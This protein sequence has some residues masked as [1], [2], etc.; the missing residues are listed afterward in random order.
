MRASTYSATWT[1]L[2]VS[3]NRDGRRKTTIPSLVTTVVKPDGAPYNDEDG[4][5]SDDS[6]TKTR[7]TLQDVKKSIREKKKKKKK[8]RDAKKDRD[9]LFLEACIATVKQE[10]KEMAR[11]SEAAKSVGSEAKEEDEESLHANEPTKKKEKARTTTS[12]C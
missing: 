1:G 12:N 8:I 2:K 4:A 9:D 5:P 3:S 6:S 11:H 10:K 7:R